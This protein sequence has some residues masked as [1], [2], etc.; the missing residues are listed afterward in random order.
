MRTNKKL[1]LLKDILKKWDITA[2]DFSKIYLTSTGKNIKPVRIQYWCDSNYYL[3][4][5]PRT[6]KVHQDNYLERECR[7]CKKTQLNKYFTFG[8][9]N[10]YL[11]NCK[12]CMKDLKNWKETHKRN[13]PKTKPFNLSDY[14]SQPDCPLRDDN[15][16]GRKP[17]TTEKKP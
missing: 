11:I 9:K 16:F 13:T 15:G 17:K 3:E 1:T 7:T 6:L 2:G 12:K 14:I 5:T 10:C 8:K 4:E